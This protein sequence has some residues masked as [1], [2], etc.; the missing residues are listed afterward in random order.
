MEKPD[1]KRT[2]LIIGLTVVAIAGAA[3]MVQA[4]G[5]R[6]EGMD[7]A[8]RPTFEQLDADGDGSIADDLLG[9]FLKR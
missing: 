6:G 8:N 1:M 9:M 5:G 4:K 2:P 3:A 7:H